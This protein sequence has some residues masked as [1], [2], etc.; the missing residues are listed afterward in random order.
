MTDYIPFTAAEYQPDAPATALHFS[1]WFQNPVAITEGASGAPRIADAAMSSSATSA[2][3]A[4]VAARL[5]LVAAGALGSL[6]FLCKASNGSI[7]F[8]GTV[9]GSDLSPSS[10][11]PTD[12]NISGSMSGTWR[13]LGAVSTSDAGSGTKARI[14]SLFVRIA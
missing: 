7:S 11:S 12:A 6:A 13:C 8:G 3:A 14:A 1:R 4:W 2:G 9:G 10:S 5:A